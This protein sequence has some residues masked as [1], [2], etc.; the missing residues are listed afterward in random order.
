MT[1]HLISID[2][3]VRPCPTKA[4]ETR[5]VT[6]VLGTACHRC[7]GS[8]HWDFG[9]AGGTHI[10]TQSYRS[11]VPSIDGLDQ[12]GRERFSVRVVAK[13]RVYRLNLERSATLES[14]PVT[15]V[16]KH[17]L[18]QTGAEAKKWRRHRIITHCS[19]HRVPSRRQPHGACAVEV[20]WRPRLSLPYGPGIG[21]VFR[22]TGEDGT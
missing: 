15:S 3:S 22:S 19:F 1:V 17:V 6:H 8:T 13:Q 11:K 9:S 5:A 10:E 2:Y 16:S 4:R 20:D 12:P 14:W 21:L 18:L 7:L